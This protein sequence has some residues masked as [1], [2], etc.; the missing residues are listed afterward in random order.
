MYG[1]DIESSKNQITIGREQIEKINYNAKG[2]CV[3]YKKITL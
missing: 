3:L 1:K 2:Q